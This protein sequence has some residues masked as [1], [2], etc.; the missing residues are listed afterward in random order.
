MV[1]QEYAQQDDLS[2]LL[3][4]QANNYDKEQKS[5]SLNII[6]NMKEKRCSKVNGLIYADD[7]RQRK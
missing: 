1:L 7:R 3:A 5:T 4:L 6:T 2:V